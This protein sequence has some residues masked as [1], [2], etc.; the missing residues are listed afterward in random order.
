MQVIGL[1]AFGTQV[2]HRFHGIGFAVEIFFLRDIEICTY[3]QTVIAVMVQ[4]VPVGRGRRIGLSKLF[5]VVELII[6]CLEGFIDL[7]YIS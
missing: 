4:Q 5:Y 6:T 7:F 2:F 3:L 1:F